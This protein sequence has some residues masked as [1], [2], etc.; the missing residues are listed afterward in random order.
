MCKIEE[1]N[2]KHHAKGY[3]ELHY[4]RMMRGDALDRPLPNSACIIP[5]C[6][7]K[8]YGHGY[9]S[10]HYTNWYRNGDPYRTSRK[11]FVD[12]GP[13][14]VYRMYG[15]N[16]ALLYVGISNH[17][18]RRMEVHFNWKE[19]KEWAKE[20]LYMK[21]ELFPCRD[22]AKWAEKQL[23]TRNQPSYNIL[24]RGE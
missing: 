23:I 9:C 16:D 6:D 24:L 5:N 22:S 20:V 21:A 8:V 7:K 19:K 12:N 3:C 4:R 14:Y 10:R 17:L 2:R 18:S 1:C 11:P 13:T 15:S